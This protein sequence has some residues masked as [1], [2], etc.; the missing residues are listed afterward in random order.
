MVFNNNLIDLTED[1]FNEIRKILYSCFGISL[2]EN[3]RSLVIGRLRKMVMQKGFASFTDFIEHVKAD[4]SGKSMQ[5]LIDRMSTNHTF[6][7]REQD[8]FDIL[9]ASVL[10][11]VISRLASS[12]SKDLRVWCAAASSGE[13]PY[14]ILMTMMETLGSAYSNWQ[15]GLLATDIS[16]EM[17]NFAREGIYPNDRIVQIPK[18]LRLRYLRSVGEDGWQFLPEIRK[19]I[20]FRRLN[21]IQKRFP[22]KKQFHIVF[23]RN[24]MIYFDQDT[25][26]Q[27]VARLHDW[28]MPGG[29]LFI[30][31]SESIRT[32]ECPFEF[33]RPSVFRKRE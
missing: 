22:F 21:L 26:Q 32:P 25:R 29:Y 10:P 2:N 11:E 3:K 31:H 13:E 12:G 17:L 15:A 8:H 5:E 14:S 23:C 6:F 30:G 24:V 16:E 4:S 28:I 18:A 19:Q 9:A 1:E 20:A 33:V 7:F 27:L